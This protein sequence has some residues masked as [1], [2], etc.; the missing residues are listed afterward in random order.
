MK[1]LADGTHGRVFIVEEKKSGRI[2]IAKTMK[3]KK[4]NKISGSRKEEIK[5]M[6]RILEMDKCW[7][8]VTILKEHFISGG[9]LV[10]IL[11]KQGRSLNDVV[12]LNK[13]KGSV[14]RFF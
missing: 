13:Y 11:S 4:F 2:F 6:E 7:R 5:T 10:M 1:F 8:Y 9:Y 14:F 12:K 3:L